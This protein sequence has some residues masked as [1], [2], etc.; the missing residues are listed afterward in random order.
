MKRIVSIIIWLLVLGAVAYVWINKSEV[1]EQVTDKIV[2]TV[3]PEELHPMMIEA[4]RERDYTSQITIEQDLGD[5]GAF[6]SYIISYPS[7]G[8]KVRALMNVPDAPKPAGG[9][10]VLFLN[11]GFI[12]PSNY[13][14][15]SSYKAFMDYYS[16]NGFLVL[17]PDYRGHDDSE[18]EAQ[19]GHTNPDYTVDVL[20]LLDA[21]KKY[22]DA[23]PEKI[24]MWGHSMGGSITLRAIVVS[25]DIKA[26]MLVAGVVA[27][28]KSFVQYGIDH[29]D[30]PRA[31]GYIR[32]NAD[33]VNALIGQFAERIS[34]YAYLDFIAGPVSVH[35]G[36]AD[37]SVPLEFSH[38]IRDALQ[39][40]GKSVEYYEYPNA[41]H[42]L[43]NAGSRPLFLQ[44][45]LDFFNKN[46]K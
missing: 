39:A 35:H 40:A 17:K 2:E 6:R 4:L 31:P 16:R 3:I 20:S 21:I 7:E 9:W 18:G 10:P 36:T 43:A 23:N 42:N 44:R 45:S 14:I 12:E 26:S 25:K 24:G 13:S 8:L 1:K 41:D 15:T 11:H 28:P 38:E 34:P 33:F 19:G 46:L 30:D 29:K 5:M 27:S 22:P 37:A 32:N